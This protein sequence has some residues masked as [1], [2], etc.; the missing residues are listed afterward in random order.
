MGHQ[1]ETC[2]FPLFRNIF[3]GD[4]PSQSFNV[5]L[6]SNK[7]T[8]YSKPPPILSSAFLQESSR[9]AQ[10][11]AHIVLSLAL[12]PTGMWYT[13]TEKWNKRQD[14]Y[15]AQVNALITQQNLSSFP[16]PHIHCLNFKAV[17]PLNENSKPIGQLVSSC[18]TPVSLFRHSRTSPTCL[19][20][21]ILVLL[22]HFCKCLVFQGHTTIYHFLE[23]TMQLD[24]I[25]FISHP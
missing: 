18:K 23:Y 7:E 13:V 25:I 17:S 20:W 11:A 1:F 8:A 21:F 10:S 12:P 15:L 24:K 5:L 2:T 19:Q 6:V 4:P 14:G 22:K 16:C 9:K 3:S